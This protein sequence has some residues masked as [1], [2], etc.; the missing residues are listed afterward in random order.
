L[1]NMFAADYSSDKIVDAHY[2]VGLHPWHIEGSDIALLI[3]KVKLA[4][5][6]PAVLAIGE[7]GL[8]KH[9][10]TPLDL[11]MQ[12]FEAQLEIAEQCSKPVIVHAVRS[13]NELIEF[14]KAHRPAMPMII[15]GFNGGVQI[16]AD[17]LKAGYYLSLGNRLMDSDKLK[18]VLVHMP[19]EKMFLE[20]D[21][22]DN[23]IRELYE[24]LANLRVISV[25]ILKGI[26]S[27]NAKR[28]FGG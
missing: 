5:K 21:E 20:T 26:I 24:V 6:N 4:T 15:H 10:Q 7:T 17:L 8:D 13:Y 28:V 16:A 22:A 12:V 9:I 25:E 3:E 2:S 18:A 1:T 19:L 11:Q 23:D 14:A 27:E